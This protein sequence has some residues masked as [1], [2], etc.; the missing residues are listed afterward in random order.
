MSRF[1]KMLLGAVTAMV[2]ASRSSSQPRVGHGAAKGVNALD[3]NVP[4][5]AW[6]GEHVRLGFCPPRNGR[7]R[8]PGRHQPSANVSWVLEDWSG[9]PANGSV[10]V[11]VEL[12]GQRDN[13]HGCVYTE[14]TSQKAGVTFIKLDQLPGLGGG[15]ASSPT[16]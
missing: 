1:K 10:P 8:D 5:L 14:F 9:D 11:P 4:Y 2:L 6:R 13:Y 16:T 15:N 7:A 3:A 12:F